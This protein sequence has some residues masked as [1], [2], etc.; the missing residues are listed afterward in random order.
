MGSNG[1]T[2]AR[3]DIFSSE[4]AVRYPESYNPE[5]PEDLTYTGKYRLTDTLPGV[6]VN[7]GKLVCLP[8]EHMRRCYCPAQEGRKYIHGLVHCSGGA[9]TKVLHFVDQVKVIKDNLFDVPPLFD[10]IYEQSATSWEEMYKVFNMGHRMKCI[11]RRSLHNRLLTWLGLSLLMPASLAA[12][13]R[14]PFARW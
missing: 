9:Q 2:S 6:P 8:P 5:I 11:P 3:H 4:Y 12:W 14:H 7:M 13:R 1:L 10:L